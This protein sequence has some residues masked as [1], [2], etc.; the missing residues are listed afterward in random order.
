MVNAQHSAASNWVLLRALWLATCCCYRLAPVAFTLGFD[1]SLG[2]LR[3]CLGGLGAYRCCSLGPRVGLHVLVEDEVKVGR[4][5]L[6][7]VG[8]QQS[9]GVACIASSGKQRAGGGQRAGTVGH[10]ATNCEWRVKK[11]LV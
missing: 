1:D 7:P 5:S 6:R 10:I 2:G 9:Q 3:A 11:L 8:T 4:V